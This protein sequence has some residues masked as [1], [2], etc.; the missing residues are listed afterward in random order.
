MPEA[1]LLRSP[2]LEKLFSSRVRIPLLSHFLL[3]SDRRDHIRALASE[4]HTLYSAGWKELNNL[5]EAG[6]LK[7]E[8]IGGRKEYWLNPDSPIL[9]ELRTI[10]LKTIGAGDLA[11]ESMQD[12]E[13]IQVAF[14][15]GFF[16]EGEIDAQSDLD[17]MLI[18]DPDVAQHTQVIDDLE[19]RL[20]REV[21]YKDIHAPRVGLPAAG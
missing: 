11:R 7:S 14:V 3:H 12:I 16:A 15:F 4:M 5:E 8:A 10:L 13:G 19:G 2:V 20:A 1:K 6:W 17:P 21:H 9:P 18:G